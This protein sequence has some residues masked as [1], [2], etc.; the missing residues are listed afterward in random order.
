MAWWLAVR[1]PGMTHES[2]Y[3]PQVG[4]ESNQ[5]F[6]VLF[7]RPSEGP[8]WSPSFVFESL[9]HRPKQKGRWE[10]R[11]HIPDEA[12]WRNV[13]YF[14]VLTLPTT[15]RKVRTKESQVPYR[16]CTSV[17]P[18]T[19]DYS[20]AE[21]HGWKSQKQVRT[22]RQHLS[23]SHLIKK[24]IALTVWMQVLPPAHRRSIR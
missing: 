2:S 12:N 20:R 8:T 24:Q 4:L 22:A 19:S 11:C 9:T 17:M 7:V 23:K 1:Y 18:W 14:L 10:G 16:C 3:L 6:A 15:T 21:V 13:E 5:Y